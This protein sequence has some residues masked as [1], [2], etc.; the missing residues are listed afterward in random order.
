MAVDSREASAQRRAARLSLSGGV[1]VFGGKL[2]GYLLTGSSAVLSDALE[3]SVNVAAAALLLYSV[4]VAA[5]PADRDHPYGHGKVEFFSAG[6]EGTL[7]AVAAVLILVEAGR[8]LLRGPELHRIDLGLLLVSAMAALNLALGGYLIRVGRRT[9]SIALVADGKHLLTDVVTSAGVV[10]GLS[11]VWLTGFAVLD[12]LVAIAVAVHILRTGYTL[13]REAVGGLMDEADEAV[14]SRIVDALERDRRPWWIDV[15]TLRAWRSGAAQHTDLHLA[16]PRYFD[17]ER[18]HQIDDEVGASVSASAGVFADVI[19]HFDP[20]RPRHC[21]GCAVADCPVRAE[22]F[23]SRDP[24]TL[25]RSVRADE[26]LDTGEPVGA[27]AP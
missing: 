14:L 19:V 3:S 16:V 23:R 21:G 5:R 26:K 1:A 9:R 12:P 4:R 18:L 17:A 15:H 20:C 24:L 2:L 22:P 8:E 11:A 25:E 27:S 10:L 7:I 6:V 13:V